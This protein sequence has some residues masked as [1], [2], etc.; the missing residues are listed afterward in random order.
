[1]FKQKKE[2]KFLL[3]INLDRNLQIKFVDVKINFAKQQS[4]KLVFNIVTVV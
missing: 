2:N 3:L 1:M 4:E